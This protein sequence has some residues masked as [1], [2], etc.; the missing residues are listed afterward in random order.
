MFRHLT[1]LIALAIVLAVPTAVC[2]Q[3]QNLTG[4]HDERVVVSG[5]KLYD[6]QPSFQVRVQQNIDGANTGVLISSSP[7]GA[8]WQ[9]GKVLG[10][11]INRN[12]PWDYLYHKVQ[13]GNGTALLAQNSPGITIDHLFADF[14]WDGVRVTDNCKDW[15]VYRSWIADVRDDTIE[16]DHIC[17]G[18][19]RES[20]LDGVH[21]FYSATPGGG[22][23]SRPHKVEFSGNLM[24]LGCGLDGKAACEDR[25]KRLGDPWSNPVGNGQAFKINGCGQ[26]TEMLFKGNAVMMGADQDKNGTWYNVG[27]NTAKA[28][29]PFTQCIKMTPGS[30]NNRFYW[31]G[32]TPPNCSG[33]A[34]GLSFTKLY[35]ACVP[36]EF[37]LSP[38][39]FS[40]ASNDRQAWLGEVERWKTAAWQGQAPPVEPVEPPQV[41]G[42][43]DSDG[44]GVPDCADNC[45][46]NANP[47]QE[48]IDG[49]EIGNICEGQPPVIPDEEQPDPRIVKFFED[50]KRALDMALQQYLDAFGED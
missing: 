44:D 50:T 3:T 21:G 15:V 42:T 39:M 11:G 40:A 46:A 25:A 5:K 49:N 18:A 24:S 35:N 43:I 32:A 14:T 31:L 30:T 34:G 45:P 48:D 8:K 38:Q 20:F 9:G 41:C 12:K 4:D 28:N 33:K 13:P 26:W 23:A 27:F 47:G 7:A 1:A 17:N 19:V 2:G 10:T 16:N 29:L 6:A 36:A 22:G 37:K